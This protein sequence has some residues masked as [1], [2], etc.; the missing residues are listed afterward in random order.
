MKRLPAA[1]L[2]LLIF[3]GC[4]FASFADMTQFKA[5]IVECDNGIETKD[6]VW[7][8]NDKSR[9]EFNN[10][11]EIVVTRNDLKLTR[12]I[13]PKIKAYV[14]TPV[15]GT[16]A[17]F[18]HPDENANTGDLKRKFIGYEERDS[19]RMK[20]Y[21]VTVTYSGV[22]GEDKYFEWTRNDFPIPVRTESFD[23]KTW[24][25]YTK[26]SRSAID[27]A[28][29][30]RPRTYK[31][32]SAEEAER[33]LAEYEA[34]HPQ[35]KSA[36]KRTPTKRRKKKDKAIQPDNPVTSSDPTTAVPQKTE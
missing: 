15:Y 18:A 14:E 33:L 11:S 32:V 13:Y 22:N 20:K 7:I 31:Q 29:F 10:G 8:T 27:P 19:F 2:I 6:N 1:L 21:L 26:I 23:G 9:R 12:F 36:K 3:S 35:K 4:A 30:E 25:E 34:K 16:F 5:V 28:I 17:N 24:T